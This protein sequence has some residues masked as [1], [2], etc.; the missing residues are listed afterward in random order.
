MKKKIVSIF[1]SMLL[2]LTVYS[3]IGTT[4]IEDTTIEYLES[5]P[6]STDVV[7]TDNF[8][9]YSLGP[10]HGQGGWEA[11]DNNSATTGYVVNDPSHSPS[12]SAEISWYGDYS[13]D[14]VYQF[15]GISSGTWNL[16]VMQYVPSDM[17]GSSAFILLNTYNHGGPFYSWSLQLSV[18]A[19]EGKIWDFDN[20]DDWLPLVTDDWVELRVEIDFEADIQTV[21]YDGDELLS[22]SWVDGASGGGAK[23]LA[24]IDLYAD[25]VVS[26]AVYYDD[27]TLEG[28]PSGPDL[29][30][31]GEIVWEDVTAGD[32]LHDSFTVKNVGGSD[33]TI[34]WEVTEWPSWG[35]WTFDP[36]SGT[37]LTPED[38]PITVQVT[39]KAP[40]KKDEEFKGRIKVENLEDSQDFC[41]IDVSLTTPKTKQS[42]ILNFFE[43]LI[44]RF[45]LL[46]W[47]LT[48][49]LNV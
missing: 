40:D 41:I 23:N 24:C 47:I 38:D 33:T 15:S 43:K 44:Q 32:E 49:Y 11:W 2:L 36:I 22:K 12:N 39:C 28:A 20:P 10:L 7:W 25:S 13:A 45:P 37:D 17:Q 3:V 34:N 29:L 18:G 8:D 14:I 6:I 5:K 48:F 21:Y 42:F 1:V 26:T 31:E 30:C 35:E 9:S 16:S 4:N 19:S 46:D 27:F